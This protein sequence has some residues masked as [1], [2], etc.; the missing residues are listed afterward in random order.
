MVV[1]YSWSS[2]WIV[3]E[4]VLYEYYR[5]KLNKILQNLLK[6]VCWP[7]DKCTRPIFAFK[8]I[9]LGVKLKSIQS[10]PGALSCTKQTWICVYPP[11]T[12]NP[13]KFILA[14]TDPPGPNCA[15]EKLHFWC[16]LYWQRS[17]IWA[18]CSY[19]PDKGGSFHASCHF[20]PA[21]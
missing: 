4:T 12:S 6:S 7:F 8:G 16:P 14:P 11:P 15:L 1:K 13:S 5:K 2:L 21:G 18:Y 3:W 10:L 9:E 19:S 17:E 20:Y